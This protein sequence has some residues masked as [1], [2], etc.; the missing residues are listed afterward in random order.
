MRRQ[1]GL[2]LPSHRKQLS[3]SCGRQTGGRGRCAA[4]GAAAAR[5]KAGRQ[6]GRKA[7]RSEGRKVGRQ[8]GRKAGRS[9][10]RKVGRQEGT[11]SRYGRDATTWATSRTFSRA[12]S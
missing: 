9:E 4:E 3:C 8:E 5:P 6:E 1:P 12:R 11:R 7:A 10:G 2:M